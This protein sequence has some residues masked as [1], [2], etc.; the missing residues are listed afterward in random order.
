MEKSSEEIIELQKSIIEQLKLKH[1]NEIELLKYVIE[2][3]NAE[4]S[5]LKEEIAIHK[6]HIDELEKLAVE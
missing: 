5:S 3:K 4:I 2:L 1:E 6:D